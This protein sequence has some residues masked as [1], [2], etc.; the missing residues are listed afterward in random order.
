MRPFINFFLIDG[1]PLL[2]PDEGVTVTY[3]DLDADDTGRDE[4]GF[5]HRIV[6]RHGV[7][8]WAFKY[9]ALT[10]EERRYMERLFDGKTDFTF[11]HPD[12]IEADKEATCQAY[13]SKH[14]QEWQDA[15]NGQWKNY[16]FNII[17]C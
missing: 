10:E 11:T 9:S 4:A 8:T 1:E 12:R 6:L 2:A 14:S 3:T 5:M 15:R 17:E 16:K 7:G 13:R